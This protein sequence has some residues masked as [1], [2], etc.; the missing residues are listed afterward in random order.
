[1]EGIQNDDVSWSLGA[2]KDDFHWKF[3][4]ICSNGKS[5][6]EAVVSASQVL[7]GTLWLL[8]TSSVRVDGSSKYVSHPSC[9]SWIKGIQHL[10]WLV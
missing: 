9:R 7:T 8:L 6:S 1:M 3:R 5:D 10:V 2:F 4:P